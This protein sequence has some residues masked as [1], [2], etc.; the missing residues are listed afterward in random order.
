MPRYEHVSGSLFA[1]IAAAQ[2][3]RALLALPARVGNVTIPVWI[4]FVAFAV[5]ASLAIWAFR[6][7]RTRPARA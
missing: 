5:T 3:V 7:A 1:L 2:L 6:A 4:S